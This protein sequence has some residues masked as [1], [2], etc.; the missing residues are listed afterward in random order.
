MDITKRNVI[1]E[2]VKRISQS[3]VSIAKFFTDYEVPFS[4]AQYF[5]YKKQ[6]KIAGS[7]GLKDG[8]TR[9]GNRKLNHEAEAFLLGCVTTKSD[10]TLE[11]LQ[12]SLQDKLRYSVSLSLDYQVF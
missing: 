8:R 4:K 6:L 1:I 5:I 7:A 3:E 10:V 11:W 12:K 9:G 2:W